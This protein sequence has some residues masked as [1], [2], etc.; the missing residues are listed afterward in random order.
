MERAQRAAHLWIG[1]AGGLYYHAH[2][3]QDVFAEIK[4]IDLVCFGNGLHVLDSILHSSK[5]YA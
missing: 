5:I 4:V 3:R 2:E 1:L